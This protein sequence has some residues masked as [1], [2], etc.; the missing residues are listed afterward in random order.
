MQF[1]ERA[2]DYIK[3]LHLSK[4][5]KVKSNVDKEESYSNDDLEQE[6]RSQR[7]SLAIDN[8][9][10]LKISERSINIKNAKKMLE[11][12]KNTLKKIIICD[13]NEAFTLEILK[14]CSSCIENPIKL[15]LDYI[16]IS[17]RDTLQALKKVKIS[18]FKY[19]HSSVTDILGKSIFDSLKDCKYLK[20][21]FISNVEL[22]END[23]KAILNIL[24]NDQIQLTDITICWVKV[25]STALGKICQ[26]I[27]TKKSFKRL[28]IENINE[29]PEIAKYF[30]Y[31]LEN[32]VNTNVFYKELHLKNNQENIAKEITIKIED[33]KIILN[34]L[35]MS[36]EEYLLILEAISKNI[37]EIDQIIST[38]YLNNYDQS[39]END[40]KYL[41]DTLFDKFYEKKILLP[42]FWL[43]EDQKLKIDNLLEEKS[44][45]V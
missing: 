31:I 20:K 23:L 8:N 38:F 17:S 34:Y 5:T 19:T 39:A 40:D 35:D 2:L 24:N 12:S 10:L 4:P 25:T 45:S 42:D 21:I 11:S 26:G 37:G 3:Y 16:N 1:F 33:N 43:T 30:S 13:S 6:F 44:Y 7:S 22:T 28:K 9:I 27:A 15:K 32:N 29:V 41:P 36:F 18:S 14:K